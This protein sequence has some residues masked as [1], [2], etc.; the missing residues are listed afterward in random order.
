MTTSSRYETYLSACEI[1]PR[2]ELVVRDGQGHYNLATPD[3]ILDAAQQVIRQKT[4]RGADFKNPSSA[5]QFLIPKMAELEHEVFVVMFLDVRHHLI[6][7]SEMFRGTYNSAQVHPREVVK[8]A[9]RFNA[10]SVILAHN[11][12]SGNSDP[13]SADRHITQMIKNA[14]ALVDVSVLDHF[15]IGGGDYTSFAARGLL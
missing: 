15:V 3:Q 8:E 11:H 13:S 2:P 9:L 6:E 1:D 4:K 5:A 10:A 14:L 7:Y 12:P